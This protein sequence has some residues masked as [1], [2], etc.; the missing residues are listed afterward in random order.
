MVVPWLAFACLTLL[1]LAAAVFDCRRGTIP[2]ALNYGGLLAGLLFWLLAGLVQGA[3]NAP[4][5]PFWGSV[6]GML[7]FLI[8]FGLLWGLGMMGGGD[9]KLLAAMG[10]WLGA[11]RPGLTA[12]LYFL[13]AGMVLAVVLMV[14]RRRTLQTI[15]GLWLLLVARSSATG[16]EDGR[17]D[18]QL[19]Y[20]VAIAVGGILAASE[21]WLKVDYPWSDWVRI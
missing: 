21:H 7:L 10:A 18:N 16:L 20:A 13:L 8:P 5:E 3:G 17:S 19:P 4:L 6:A 1:L 2:N 15:R 14:V 12:M 11:L 9:A